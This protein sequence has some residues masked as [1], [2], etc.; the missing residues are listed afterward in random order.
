MKNTSVEE[1]IKKLSLPKQKILSLFFRKRK[2]ILTRDEIAKG[3]GKKGRG[4]GG[5]LGGFTQSKIKLLIRVSED[6]WIINET[7]K[8]EVKRAIS[9]IDKYIW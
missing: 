3:I 2:D 5:I 7:Y 1:F 4:L 6:R 8:E 9:K